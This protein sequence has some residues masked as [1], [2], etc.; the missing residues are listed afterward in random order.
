[1]SL[2]SE[3]N[4]M[5]SSQWSDIDPTICAC[6]GSGWVLSDLDTWHKC[7]SHFNKELG[8]PEENDY[9]DEISKEERET[10][11]LNEFIKWKK[12]YIKICENAIEWYKNSTSD[13][14]WKLLLK[15]LESFPIQEY[16][17]LSSYENVK[18]YFIS[19]IKIIREF[20]N[21]YNEQLRDDCDM[22]TGKHYFDLDDCEKIIE[23]YENQYES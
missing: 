13:K 2:Q 20:V 14:G 21:E 7:S 3:Y 12:H 16:D 9:F 10:I 1:M 17:N 22:L 11:R 23:G 4:Y 8:H 6:K 19:Y 15:K 5:E 18:D